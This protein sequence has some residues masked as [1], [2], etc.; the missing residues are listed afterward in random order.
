MSLLLYVTSVT[1]SRDIGKKQQRI[2]DVL[3][4]KHI[5]YTE[6]DLAREP[7]EKDKMRELCGLPTALPPQ[8]FNG[9]Q[10]CG[11]YQAFDDAVEEGT[12]MEFLRLKA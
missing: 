1:T 7:E 12:L 2:K 8:I 5:P 3:D 4:I 9:D 11:D 10:Y 6:V